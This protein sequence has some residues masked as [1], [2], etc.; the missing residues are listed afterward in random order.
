MDDINYRNDDIAKMTTKEV[1]HIPIGTVSNYSASLLYDLH[2]EAVAEFEDARK[3]RQWIESAIGMKYEEKVRAKRVRL[4]KDS[5]IVHI[6]D[7]EFRVTNDAPKKVEWHQG[8]LR[9]IM[10]GL[11][12]NGVDIDEFVETIYK[13]PERRFAECSSS[14]QGSFAAA[15]RV[16]L[17]KESY[18][19]SRLE[20]GGD[21][22]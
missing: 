19:L 10:A 18:K 20:T 1:L 14:L 8:K 15:R 11:I 7:D 9:G 5:G 21:H 2:K 4:E 3:T 12:A 6:E 13:I 16:R 17:G 22:E